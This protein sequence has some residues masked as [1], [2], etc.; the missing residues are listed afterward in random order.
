MGLPSV[1][2]TEVG[3]R[4]GRSVTTERN[5]ITI[6]DCGRYH[7]P[8]NSRGN[9]SG[10]DPLRG[11]LLEASDR[12]RPPRI[13][14]AIREENVGW[15][16]APSTISIVEGVDVGLRGDRPLWESIQTVLF[17]VRLAQE[18]RLNAP[19]VVRIS[20]LEETYT[21]TSN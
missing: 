6:S 2:N 17:N 14:L 5:E 10:S 16:H 9:S 1:N 11:I 18:L 3:R 20:T 21:R 7:A 8:G 15:V 13:N 4:I 19:V 12:E